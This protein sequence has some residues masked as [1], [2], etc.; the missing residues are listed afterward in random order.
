MSTF[1]GVMPDPMANPMQQGDDGPSGVGYFIGVVLIVAGVICG[2]VWGW[3]KFSDFQDAIDDF[4]RV[5]V[6]EIGTVELDEGDYVVYAEKGG[7]DAVTAFL[8]GVRMRPAG[9]RRAD[10]IQFE[11]YESEFTYDFGGRAGNAQLTFEIEDEGEYRVRVEEVGST[12][13]TAAFGPSVAPDLVSAIVG[14]F[15]IAG[16]GILLGITFLIVTGVRRR[17]HRQRGWMAAY[18]P[19]PGTTGPAPWNPGAPAP[20][21]WNPA[22]P[23]PGSDFPPPP[24]S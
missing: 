23:P 3:T 4:Q 2:G 21:T 1:P 14:A 17:K 9:E 5:P 15:V 19:F 20:G 12:A 22:P 10:E 11:T 6:G 18:Q 24:Y 7:G 8:G 13:T 16:A